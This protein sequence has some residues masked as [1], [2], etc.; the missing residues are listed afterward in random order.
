MKLLDDPNQ[1][2]HEDWAKWIGEDYDWEMLDV[3][4][5]VDKET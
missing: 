2:E 4:K 5:D 1:T 3:D